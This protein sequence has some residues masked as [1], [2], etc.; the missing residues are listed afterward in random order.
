MYC[1]LVW[2]NIPNGNTVNTQLTHNLGWGAVTCSRDRNPIRIGQLVIDDDPQ[3][4]DRSLII[5]RVLTLINENNFL[6]VV[7]KFFYPIWF[8]LK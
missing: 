7:I 5:K 8:Y 6:C 4:P 3:Q 1:Q 2:N